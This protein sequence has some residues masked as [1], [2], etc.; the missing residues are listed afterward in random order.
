[1]T[2]QG[3]N[4]TL[5]H[6]GT[7]KGLCEIICEQGFEGMG[8]VLQV[9]MNEAMK[10]ERSKFL[11]TQPY[12]R[13]PERQDYANGF[14]DKTVKTRL[15]MLDLQVP[16]V[17][18]CD[19][20][21][22]ALERGLRSEQALRMSVAEMYLQGV[23]TRKVQKIT[24]ELCVLTIS[25]SQ[26]SR[27]TSKLDSELK[28]WRDRKLGKFQYMI[29]DAIYEKT[30]RDGCVVSSSVLIAYGINPDGKREVIGV[31]VSLSEAEV[32][33]RSFFENL[34]ERGLHGLEMITS[35]AHTGLKAALQTIFPT[36]PWQR[37]QF[38]LQ[39]N[40]SSYVTK[41]ARKAEV[42]ADIRDIF[43]APNETEAKRLLGLAVDKYKEKESRLAEW[44]GSN[45]DESFTVFR[46]PKVHRQ[47]LRTSNLAE[48]VNKEIRRRT[49]VVGIFSNE[50]SCLRLVSAILCEIHEEWI[51]GKR[52]LPEDV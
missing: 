10:V 18:G 7:I 38:H 22:Q 44:I 25:S 35:D 49:K 17:R 16:Q 47:K 26:V 3:R 51:Q 52:Y 11:G 34:V 27:I 1:M 20:Y 8:Q 41:K 21:P 5:Y 39:Q 42:A 6:S 31:S 40:A 24:E 46:L 9:L 45:I 33:W 32:H 48:R 30:R 29:V 28:L 36:V 4:T 12:E 43:N 14:K 19:F 50:E 15:G 13:S 2:Y 23:S 37:C